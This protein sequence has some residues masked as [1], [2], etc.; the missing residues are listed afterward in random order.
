MKPCMSDWRENYRNGVWT[1][2]SARNY[3]LVRFE[4]F[5]ALQ[6]DRIRRDEE[7]RNERARKSL[8]YQRP[9]GS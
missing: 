8:K 1:D 9:C 5:C 3:H 2:Q 6:R 7:E 4:V